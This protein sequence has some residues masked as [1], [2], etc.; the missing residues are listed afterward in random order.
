M[1]AIKGSLRARSGRNKGTRRTLPKTNC[2]QHTEGSGVGGKGDDTTFYRPATSNTEIRNPASIKHSIN[3]QLDM[4][5]QHQGLSWDSFPRVS[6]HKESSFL[7]M[8]IRAL[9]QSYHLPLG[10]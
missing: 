1:F 4:S 6:L 5:M 8:G 9:G 2:P 7:D 10:T 3:E